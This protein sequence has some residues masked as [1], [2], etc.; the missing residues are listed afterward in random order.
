MVNLDRYGNTSAAALPIALARRLIKARSRTAIMRCWSG[1]GSGMTWAS[2]VM[3]W[4]PNQPAEEEAI[5]VADW[6]IRE[7][8]QLQATKMRS[9]VW[10]AQVTA[11]T[12]AQEASMSVMVPFY[13]WQR[14]RRKAK[15]Q[16]EAKD[17]RAAV[18]KK[19]PACWAGRLGA[20]LDDT[21]AFLTEE[22]SRRLAST[23]QARLRAVAL[24]LQ[25]PANGLGVGQAG[26]TGPRR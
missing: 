2:V 3:L 15:E 5:L 9:A 17:G 23:A 18:T 4:E 1:F 21:C 26:T 11:R 12:K 14:K 8:L 16:E 13:T 24:G 25:I 22:S 20:V 19:P 6:P 10:S 7:S